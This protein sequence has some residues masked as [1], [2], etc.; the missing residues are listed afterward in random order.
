MGLIVSDLS[1]K[2]GNNTVVN[3]ISFEMDK[4][5]V[6]ALLGTNGAGKTT[7]IRMMLNMLSKDSGKVL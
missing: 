5:G 4:P 7:T 6:Y 3:H 2:Y 1:K